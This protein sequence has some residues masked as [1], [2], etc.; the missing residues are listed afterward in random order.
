MR[1]RSILVNLKKWFPADDP[2]AAKIARLS[3]LK[4]DLEIEYRA[5]RQDNFPD[6]DRNGIAWRKLY[7]FRNILRT[8]LEIHGAVQS[9]KKDRAFAQ[10]ILNQPEAVRKA[11][12][13]LSS[14][15]ASAHERIKKYRNA[16]GG[17]VQENVL[18]EALNNISPGRYDFLEFDMDAK[19][20]HYKF[21]SELC[22]A[23]LFDKIPEE[24]QLA[25]AEEILDMLGK[26]LPFKPLDAIIHTYF[27]SR[28][29]LPRP[30]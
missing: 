21:T 13:S 2:V 6:L 5:C 22:M 26:T 19:Q 14:E 28:N 9:L 8:M 25:K 20:F 30:C 27:K 12:E 29:L 24:K 16:I 7:F 15:L 18:S 23:I 3:I 10:A 11:Y 17:H 1:T 4:E